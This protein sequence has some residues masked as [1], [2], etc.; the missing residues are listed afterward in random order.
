MPKIQEHI[1]INITQ[2]NFSHSSL[3]NDNIKIKKLY[4]LSNLSNTNGFKLKSPKK[5]FE[6]TV[7]V[8]HC[9]F[10]RMMEL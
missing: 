6:N 7:K 4:F 2:A 3:Y 5:P 9:K 10:D 8:V 1:S